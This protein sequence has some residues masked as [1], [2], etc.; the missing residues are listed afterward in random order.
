LR[1]TCTRADECDSRADVNEPLDH[2]FS[3]AD[4]S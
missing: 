2:N 3:S 4:E 1:K